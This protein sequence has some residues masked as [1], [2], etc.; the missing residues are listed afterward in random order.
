MSLLCCLGTGVGWLSSPCAHVS[1]LLS[2]PPEGSVMRGLG[3]IVPVC[4]P[5]AAAVRP[6][7]PA[8]SAA[9]FSS[10]QTYSF[11]HPGAFLQ[12]M[13][14][15]GRSSPAQPLGGPLGAPR[16]W[17]VCVCV[18]SVPSASCGSQCSGTNGRA[19]AAPGCVK[20][21]SPASGTVSP[22]SSGLKKAGHQTERPSGTR[23]ASCGTSQTSPPASE[24]TL[25]L[26]QQWLCPWLPDTE[27]SQATWSVD[28]ED[29]VAGPK[30]PRGV[31][32]GGYVSC[33]CFTCL[34]VSLKQD[35][36]QVGDSGCA[37]TRTAADGPGPWGE[38]ESGPAPTRQAPRQPRQGLRFPCSCPRKP[39]LCSV[40]QRVTQATWVERPARALH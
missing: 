7:R 36:D 9:P 26:W 34:V 20:Q 10:A 28:S 40:S 14:V 2:R 13:G 19:K 23:S 3:R 35:A 5:R 27:L 11:A 32:T 12:S 31:G 8:R 17:W 33:V 4:P 24:R 6:L 1:V 18:G 16:L 39:A 21:V 29:A 25:V 37:R 15:W 38:T 30:R 22:A